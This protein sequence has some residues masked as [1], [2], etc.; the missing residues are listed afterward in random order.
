MVL[1]FNFTEKLNFGSK[2]KLCTHSVKS[3][4]LFIQST[5]PLYSFK[6]NCLHCPKH[7]ILLISQTFNCFRSFEHSVVFVLDI[8]Q[9]ILFNPFTQEFYFFHSTKNCILFSQKNIPFYLFS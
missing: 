4:I 7:L 2:K 8:Q 3:N 6:Q 1:S 5:I 9:K